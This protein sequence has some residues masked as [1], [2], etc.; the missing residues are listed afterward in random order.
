MKEWTTQQFES[1]FQQVTAALMETGDG[2]EDEDE[3]SDDDRDLII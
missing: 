3:D 1:V 2:N